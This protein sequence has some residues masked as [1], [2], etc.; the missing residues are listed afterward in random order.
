MTFLDLPS[1]GD[2]MYLL[3]REVTVT[4][5]YFMFQLIKIY[6]TEEHVEFFVDICAVTGY[7]DTTN[8]ISLRL[9]KGDRS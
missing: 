3:Q 2:K 9:L 7:P 6:Y 4:K 8:S 1:I 5:V